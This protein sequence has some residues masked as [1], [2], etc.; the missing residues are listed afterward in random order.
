MGQNVHS[1]TN[2]QGLQTEKLNAKV[3]IPICSFKKALKSYNTNLVY[4]HPG[5]LTCE[6]R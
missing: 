4:S 5:E 2:I 6:V 3:E 1:I